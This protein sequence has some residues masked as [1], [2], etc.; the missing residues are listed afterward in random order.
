LVLFLYFTRYAHYKGRETYRF[1]LY[2]NQFELSRA[3]N[4]DTVSLMVNQSY[5]PQVYILPNIQL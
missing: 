3:R 2:M 5:R 1:M 4:T